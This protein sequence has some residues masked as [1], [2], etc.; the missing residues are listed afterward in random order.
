MIYFALFFVYFLGHGA[1]FSAMSP[2]VMGKFPAHADLII[3]VSQLSSPIGNL[4]A[5]YASDKSRLLRVPLVLALCGFG[6][7]QFIFFLDVTLPVML[8]ATVALR[9]FLSGAGQ[10]IILSCLEAGAARFARA[11]TAGTVG[12]S[13]VQ[14]ALFGIETW[15]PVFSPAVLAR[16]AAI[17]H[18]LT[19]VLALR[20][21]AHRLSHDEYHFK[22]AAGLIFKPRVILFFAISFVYYGCYQLVDYYLGRFL[23]LTGGIQQVYLGWGF[24]VVFEIA[25]MPFTAAIFHRFPARLLFLVSLGAGFLR[26]LWL[27]LSVHETLPAPFLSQLL[28]GLHFTGFYAAAIYL[29]QRIFPPHLYGTG[30]A[31]YTIFAASAGGIAG[32]ILTGRLL[33]SGPSAAEFGPVFGTAAL[34]TGLMLVL[35]ALM[36]LPQKAR[37]AAAE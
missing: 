25:L 6:V 31:L 11:R 26:F 15:F 1:Y 3:L 19:A 18:F 5:G 14:I 13:A 28:H 33:G 16:T 21:P 20:V 17:F 27:Y 37:F 32:N 4:L 2:Y 34:L 24:S 29:L 23:E 35:F 10:L 30:H 9:I 36:P 22:E 8:A 12:F 7:S